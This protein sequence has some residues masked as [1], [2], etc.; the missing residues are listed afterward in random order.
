MSV[1]LTLPPSLQIRLEREGEGEGEK[2]KEGGGRTEALA[3]ARLG[4]WDNNAET[5]NASP[6]WEQVSQKTG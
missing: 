6:L 1:L 2:D 5:G 4:A 3:A